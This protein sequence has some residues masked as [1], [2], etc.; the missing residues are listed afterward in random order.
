MQQRLGAA[1]LSDE[2]LQASRQHAIE[3]PEKRNKITFSRA[4]CANE[5]PIQ[6]QL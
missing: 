6:K 5:P 3:H 2:L 1:F 4:V